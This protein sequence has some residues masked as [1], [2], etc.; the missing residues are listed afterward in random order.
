MNSAYML[1]AFICGMMVGMFVS[2]AL[3]RRDR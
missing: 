3:Q 2:L 1:S